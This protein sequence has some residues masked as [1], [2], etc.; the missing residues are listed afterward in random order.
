MQAAFE[1]IKDLLVTPE[2]KKC[3]HCPLSDLK[4]SLASSREVS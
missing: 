1:I 4:R 3:V 2:P